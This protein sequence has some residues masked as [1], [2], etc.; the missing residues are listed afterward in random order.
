MYIYVHGMSSH[1]SH[2]RLPH[3]AMLAL[4]LQTWESS[5]LSF[6]HLPKHIFFQY[7]NLCIATFNISHCGIPCS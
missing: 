7:S 4:Q 5:F 1:V 2:C 3:M 6:F